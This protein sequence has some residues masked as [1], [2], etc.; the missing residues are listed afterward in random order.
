MTNK[1][2]V[3][4][5]NPIPLYFQVAQIIENEI[6]AGTLKPGDLFFDGGR[7]AAAV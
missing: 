4:R 2:S 5:K 7:I 1:D 3:T 6:K